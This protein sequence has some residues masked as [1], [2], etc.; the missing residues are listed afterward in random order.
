MWVVG[1]SSLI[2]MVA[3]RA[4]GTSCV[5]VRAAGGG[6]AWVEDT[7]EGDSHDEVLRTYLLIDAENLDLEI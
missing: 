4:G 5:R 1:K 6:P 3:D 7:R 2:V